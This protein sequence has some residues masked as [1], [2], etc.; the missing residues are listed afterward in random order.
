MIDLDVILGHACSGKPLLEPPPNRTSIESHHVRKDSHRLLRRVDD[1]AGDVLVHDFWNRAAAKRENRGA[2]R[3]RFDHHQAE[4]LGPVDGE[5]E[6]PCFAEKLDLAPLA[7][8][9]DEFHPRLV[10]QRCDLG[11]KIGFIGLVHLGCNLQRNAEC[12]CDANGAVRALLRGD[13]SEEGHVAATRIANRLVQ[14]GGN[15][16]VNGCDEV[17]ARHRS[18]LG[19]GDRNE[20]HLGKTDIERLEIRDVLPAV[21]GCDRSGSQ[22]AKQRKMELVDVEMQ[23]IELLGTLPHP[24]EH[25]HVIWDRI[26]NVVV[27]AQRRLRA[28]HQGGARNRITGRE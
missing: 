5:Q 7:D 1:A 18:A 2:A 16:V 13:S 14:V 10:E 24:I 6:R 21:Q 4:W 22:R 20:R 25:Q 12:L 26:A 11:S 19:M 27:Q 8:L 3:H 17:A 23:Y 9:S 28:R 15:A